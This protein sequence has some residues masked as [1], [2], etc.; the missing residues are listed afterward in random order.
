MI[1]LRTRPFVI[2]VS[3]L[4][5]GGCSTTLLNSNTLD[6]AATVDDLA[7]RQVVFNLAKTADNKWALPSQVFVTSGQVSGRTSVTPG[8]TSPF[9]YALTSTSQIASVLGGA[10]TK[11]SIDT[12]NTPNSGA[13]LSGLVEDTENWNLS[14]L[15]DPEQL[16][17]LRL[18]YQY[19]AKKITQWELLCEYPIPQ[20][21]EKT[22]SAA[23][24]TA[25]K[26]NAKAPAPKKPIIYIR[27][28]RPERCNNISTSI[29][30]NA[31][32]RS[33]DWVKVGTDP[34][35]AFLNSP[36][37]I[38]CA[39]PNDIVKRRLKRGAHIYDNTISPKYKAYN[40]SK[41]EYIP[42][43]LN[44]N[45]LPVHYNTGEVYI[46]WLFV[47]KDGVD[48]IPAGNPRRIGSSNGYTV[49]STD[50]RKFSEFVLAIS[51]ATLQSPEL[52]KRAPAAPPPIVQTNPSAR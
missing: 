51:E 11:T 27:G 16:R 18:L 4:L 20:I 49:Y 9:N 1:R 30:A 38:L 24:G 23:A 28:D 34:D 22:E 45:L 39:W 46:D 14:P 17:R 6:L 12:K 47:V 37:C 43:V 5:L 25:S 21:P 2:A 52:Q 33:V 44:D 13:T 41:Y 42:V 31:E 40:P 10:T 29:E 7:V 8:F 15:Q 26:T 36:G 48:P 35:P 3:L 19:G 50:D 32:G